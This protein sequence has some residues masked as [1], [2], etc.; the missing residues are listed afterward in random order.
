MSITSE[1]LL[2][3]ALLLGTL[4][5]LELDCDLALLLESLA[6]F[7]LDFAFALED[8][9]AI[10]LEED[11]TELLLDLALLDEETTVSAISD[12]VEESI[13]SLAISVS[14]AGSVALLSPPQA[15]SASN[16]AHKARPTK[17]RL[18]IPPW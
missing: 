7:E 2:D 18:M 5:S 15:A 11:L 9:F 1:L 3:L 17:K 4:I 13:G 8:V 12:M 14:Q 6:L 10:E 16:K